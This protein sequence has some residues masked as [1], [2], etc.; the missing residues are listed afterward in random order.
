MTIV[1]VR[2]T[3]NFPERMRNSQIGKGDDIARGIPDGFGLGSFSGSAPVHLGC[4]AL[5]RAGDSWA[6]EMPPFEHEHIMGEELVTL[7]QRGWFI[8]PRSLTGVFR[9]S[10]LRRRNCC[11]HLRHTKRKPTNLC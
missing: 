1:V 7:S 8:R 9:R 11:R 10:C 2:K 3:W 4:M 6:R 5:P